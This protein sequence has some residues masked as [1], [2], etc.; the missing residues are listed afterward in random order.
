MKFK[1]S[2]LALFMVFGSLGFSQFKFNEYSCSNVG[3]VKDP[4][5][6]G[7]ATSPDWVEIYNTSTVP[8]KLT[9]WYI[10]D[11]RN[12]LRKWQVSLYN[13]QN[14]YVDSFRVQVIFLNGA[15]KE[16]PGTI[17]TQSVNL[18]TNFQLNQTASPWLYLNNGGPKPLDSVKIQRSQPDHSW[19]R[20]PNGTG[21]WKLYAVNNAG[22]KNPG[23]PGACYKGYAPTPK[24]V[25]KPGYY[26]S[27]GNFSLD[28][29]DT[30]STSSPYEIYASSDCT[31]PQYYII[32]N[33]SVSS[34]GSNIGSLTALTINT[35][36]GVMVRAIAVD[37]SATNATSPTFTNNNSY[38]PSFEAYGAYILDSIYKMG[39]TCA[40]L[41]TNNIKVA[42]DTAYMMYDFIGKDKKEKVKNFGQAMINKI[43][44]N[45]S[46]PYGSPAED[47]QFQFR[48][49][50]EYGYN[51]SNRY[52][53]FT[54]ANLGVTS[55]ADYPEL[56]FRASAEDHFLQGGVGP[57]GIGANHLRDL[58]NHTYNL[59]HKIN[60]EA[61]H[62]TPT[63]LIVNGRNKGIYYIKEP[64]DTSYTKYYFNYT[65]AD[66]IAND[67]TPGTSGQN[68]TTTTLAGNYA[69]W[70]NFYNFVM[71]SSTNIHDPNYYGR[72]ADSMDMASFCDYMIY[73]MYSVNEDFVKRQ[74]LYWRGIPDDTS[75]HRDPKWRFALTNTDMTWG[76]NTHNYTNITDNGENTSPCDYQN[77]SPGVA[78]STQYSLIRMFNKLMYNDTFKNQFTSR[79]MDLLN[80]AYSCDSIKPHFAYLRTLLLGDMPSHV[81]FNTLSG[82][83]G[84]S[85][86]YWKVQCDSMNL[87]MQ[88]RCSLALKSIQSAS[89][90]YG[91]SLDGPYNICVDVFP[92]KSGYVKFNTLTIKN[93]V[94]NGKYLDSIMNS[95]VGIPDTNYVFDHW[96][97][98]YD[99]HPDK[100]T[101]SVNFFINQNDC[102][103]AFFKLKPADQT[104]GAPMIP[105]AFSPNG[106]NNNDI[107]NVYGIAKATSYELF[108]YNRW[109]EQLFF[110]TDKTK[111]WDGTYNG[112]TVPVGIYAYRYNI[113][114]N[115]K[116]YNKH[117]SV[118]L[119]R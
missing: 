21:A 61:S 22:K 32:S 79:Y 29:K 108:V 106:D 5:A 91:D 69:H 96:E 25:Q 67:I 7:Y 53:F 18:H 27:G 19:G 57:S 31:P 100:Y 24:L 97:T 94:W 75:D 49:E 118:T 56:T 54:D 47:Y 13:N 46:V 17:G 48:S 103:K 65:H 43:D 90:F 84:D 72:I 62:Y 89:C 30:S 80:T 87:F 109:G 15:N 74:A 116:T 77:A 16:T 42:A 73:N 70:T 55:R 102:I 88:R 113:V 110:S 63:Y 4:T 86:H 85:V 76:L 101:D 23:T 2:L 71:S 81:W 58:F 51:Y 60:F 93:F 9:G 37:T 6:S 105:T 119:L 64:F 117:G 107:L 52:N 12:N 115:G 33:P 104:Y 95:A 92:P 34:L 83:T 14:I 45:Q 40:C 112:K 10:S 35:S 44:F 59:R 111:G 38:L 78:P 68:F 8:K 82:G 36:G 1:Y 66:I 99:L 26:S 3:G 50:D 114:I 41:D 98:K 20:Y 39:V 28:I 11:D